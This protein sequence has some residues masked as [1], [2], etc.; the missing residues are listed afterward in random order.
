MAKHIVF[1]LLLVGLNSAG[2]ANADSLLD[3]ARSADLNNYALGVTVAGTGNIYKGAED[4]VFLFPNLTTMEESALTD[5]WI[6]VGEGD[7]GFR[8]IKGD[9]TIG[10]VGRIQTLG[11]DESDELNG[12]DQRRWTLEVAPAVHYRAWPIQVSFKPYFELSNRHEGY[13]GQLEFLYPRQFD[14]GYMTLGIEFDYMSN[15]YSNYYFGVTP[16]ES[17]VDRPAYEPGATVN[18]ELKLKW[19]Y[20]LSKHWLVS[21]NVG[22]LLL[23]DDVKDSPLID[24]DQSWSTSVGIAYNANVFQPRLGSEQYAKS[25]NFRIRYTMLRDELDTR[26]IRDASSSASGTIIRVEDTLGLSAKETVGQLDFLY[27]LG[28]FHRFELSY[29]AIER[30]G[31]TE[32]ANDIVVGDKFFPAGTVINSKNE[33]QT[34]RLSYGYSLIRDNQKEIGVTAGLH[35]TRLETSIVSTITGEVASN[36]PDPILP[37]IGTYGSVVIGPR[38]TV[39]AEGQFSRLD[40]DRFSGSLNYARVEVLYELGRVGLGIGY[41]YYSIR[42]DSTNSDFMGAV[43]FRH[44]GPSASI[45]MKI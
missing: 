1:T 25:P 5:D 11:F 26:I 18:A 37:T 13:M 28:G 8:I 27:R 20:E 42:L 6:V 43:E 16:A 3:R 45:S 2:V 36:R 38:T 39:Y 35:R 44:Q 14:N 24:G 7:V 21:G 31:T 41:S 23:N 22:L 19:G 12:V 9:W 15:D 40:Y 17:A 10:A 29:S 30:S 34:M 4:S 32:T 33:S